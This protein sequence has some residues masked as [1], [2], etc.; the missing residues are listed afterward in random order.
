MHWHAWSAWSPPLLIAIIHS[1]AAAVSRARRTCHCLLGWRNRG[2][3]IARRSTPY[4]VHVKPL[5]PS[6][7]GV[8]NHVASLDPKIR[9][10]LCIYILR[11]YIC[12]YISPLL[13]VHILLHADRF[14]LRPHPLYFLTA[15]CPS[16]HFPPTAEAP[17][18][19]KHIIP[20]CSI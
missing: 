11:I 9:S 5:C 7:A 17:Q 8:R 18:L 19:I 6:R 2:D 20:R 15:L 16:R 14:V 3:I 1:F 10:S 13:L 4:S 12:I